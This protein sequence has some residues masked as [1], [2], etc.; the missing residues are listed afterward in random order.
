MLNNLQKKVTPSDSHQKKDL[1]D[2]WLALHKPR[3]VLDV[4]HWLL[5]WETSYEELK[6]LNIVWVQGDQPT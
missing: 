4:S 3:K 6:A 2:K 5:K 1:T